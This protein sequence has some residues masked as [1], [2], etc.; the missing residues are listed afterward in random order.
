MMCSIDIISDSPPF[1][2]PIDAK[3][4]SI[5][6][7]NAMSLT[8]LAFT[9]LHH[10]PQ[11][12]PHNAPVF[13]EKIRRR[14]IDAN[15]AFVIQLG[16]FLHTPSINSSLADTY[17]DFPMPIYN[18]F[19]NH[20][21]DQE[22]LAYILR[23]YR[24]ERSYYHF[25]KDG[26][27]FIILDPN[28]AVVEGEL[29]HY[30]PGPQAGQRSHHLGELPP[31]QLAWLEKT[32]EESEYPCIL[33]SHQSLER[34]DGIKNR[35]DVWRILCAANRR[36]AHKVI[37]CINGHYHCDCCTF[38]NGV[39]CLD[40]N[41]S[42]YYWCDVKNALYSADIYE[43]YPLAANCLYYKNPL[44]AVITL[45]GTEEIRIA[46]TAGEYITP[47]SREMLLHLDQRRL[48][49]ARLCTPSIRNY[50]VNLSNGTISV[51]A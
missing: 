37:L 33:C 26:Y 28:Y 17:A 42:S 21:T 24:L 16:D 25:D 51:D 19:G 4:K 29:T 12:F 31:E 35:D 38:V 1:V 27:R 48:S 6:T 13:L 3:Q 14:A 5:T 32:I 20:D 8:F 40:L 49:D 10:E 47:V 34:T 43:K 39:C 36:K 41:S 9:D 30:A 46:G 23:M 22:D 2:N 7:E 18:A 44:S 15:A 50:T 11:V 45:C